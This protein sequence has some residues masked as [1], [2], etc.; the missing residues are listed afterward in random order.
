MFVC[1]VS[2]L[3]TVMFVTTAVRAGAVITICG[4]F[5]YCVVMD[6]LL[7]DWLKCD[8]GY[9]DCDDRRGDVEVWVT[10]VMSTLYRKKKYM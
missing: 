2:V 8:N 5:C 4:W 7:Y 3:T 9:C 6:G 1:L 10:D